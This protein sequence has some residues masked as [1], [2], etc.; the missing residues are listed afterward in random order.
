MRTA[1]RVAALLAFSLA[2]ALATAQQGEGGASITVTVKDGYGVLPGASVRV[3]HKESQATSRAVADASGGAAFSRLPA[4][5]YAVRASLTGFADT[6]ESVT[7]AAGEQKPVEL[8]LTLAQFSTTITVTTANRREEL[9]LKTAEP[10]AVI[11]E[12]QILDTGA[13]SAKDLLAEQNGSG[14]QVQAGGG[15]G[16]VSLNGIPNSGVL[17]LVDGRRYLGRD[18]NGNFNLEDLPVA[19]I[20]RVEIVKGA[21]SALYGSDAMG[22]V[23]NFITKKARNQGFSNTLNLSGGDYADYRGDDSLGY[24]GRSGGFGVSGG[25]RSYDGFDLDTRNPQT[26]GQPGSKWKTF[27][28]NSDY[29]LSG[30]VVA[31][32]L[33]DYWLRS[34]DP[35]FFSGA[36]QLASTVYNSQRE[37]ARYNVTPELDVLPGKNTTL[38]LSYNYSRYN[39]D[40]TQV[41]PNRPA[42]PVVVVPRWTEKNDEWK[43]RALQVWRAFEREHPLQAG[44]EHRQEQLSRSG[45]VGCA[46]GQA[47]NKSRDLT[48]LWAQQEVNLTKELKL[49]AGLRHDDSSD[50][51]SQTSPKA[52]AVFSLARNN[53]LRASYGKGFRAPYF[54]EL[55]LTTFGF[56][57][58]PALKPERSETFTGGYAYSGPKLS[59]SVDLFWA[60]IQDGITFAQLTPSLF[61]YDNVRR[62]DS[63]GLSAQIALNLPYGFAPSFSYTYNKR[64]DDQGREIGGYPRHAGFLKLL[65]SNPR[66]GVRANLRGELNGEVPAAFGATRFQPAYQVWYAQASKRFVVKGAYAFSVYA[67]V[68]NLFD[69]QDV[70][71]RDLQGNPVTNELLQVW[72]APRT[73]QGGVTIDMDWTK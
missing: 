6:E 31:R 54:G 47:C 53:R 55:F 35:Y 57:G 11:D 18:A 65:W 23:I 70:Y 29:S 28:A 22:G 50:Y 15:Q 62:Y 5:S 25:Y 19:G 40:E 32:L 39:R 38:G 21:G 26:I 27:S 8:L 2:P 48:V 9:L 66:L 3:T 52:A 46:S 45:L 61:T 24:R 30:K 63:N 64:E 20:E 16:H 58:N 7:L 72:L 36:T 51:G 49:S 69:K 10:T 42:N 60:Q 56:Q 14:V 44:Y 12:A 1:S 43:A 68:R 41:Y 34:I 67:Q 17:V 33:G 13:R 4:G 59:G 37:L 73:F 71:N